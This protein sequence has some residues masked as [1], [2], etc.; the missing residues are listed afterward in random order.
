MTI[1]T[2][3]FFWNGIRIN[4]EKELVKLTA[5]DNN[6]Y[7]SIGY[8]WKWSKDFFTALCELVEY[9]FEAPQYLGDSST[10]T[11]RVTKENPLYY[12]FLYLTKVNRLHYA[13]ATAKRY[14]K[15]K[16]NVSYF[17]AYEKAIEDI[18]TIEKELPNLPQYAH[19][20][21][22][23][24]AKAYIKVLNDTRQAEAAKAKA[25]E[26]AEYQAET[27][28]MREQKQI[29]TDWQARFPV[30]DN[31]PFVR[32]CWS[33]HPAFYDYEENTL[34]LSLRAAD[35]I[36]TALDEKSKF[37]GYFKTKFEIIE[38]GE[39]VYEGRYDQVYAGLNFR[40]LEP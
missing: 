17:Y 4:G 23:A 20:N 21:E 14:E 39:R 2:I 11:I 28:R 37:G 16:R 29:I 26:E 25:E 30:T 15:L 10:H 19:G 34:T 40:R 1:N 13:K 18:D 24:A 6:D 27:Q 8:D 12:H 22:T 33:E 31:A 9:E 7:I 3:K 35:L 36:F 32:V 38:N 5:Q